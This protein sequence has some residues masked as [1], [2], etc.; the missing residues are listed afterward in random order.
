MSQYVKSVLYGKGGWLALTTVTAVVL[1]ATVSLVTQTTLFSRAAISGLTVDPLITTANR[2]I[3]A[4]SL[5]VPV[6]GIDVVGSAGESIDYV[7]VSVDDAGGGE[8]TYATDLAALASGVNE[9]SG[10]ALYVDDG[11]SSGQFDSTDSI[12]SSSALEDNG[13]GEV[14]VNVTASLPANDTGANSGDDFYIV[15][16]SGAD[17]ADTDAGDDFDVKVDNGDLVFSDASTNGAE[18]A[19]T[20]NLI[21]DPT[22]PTVSS[23]TTVDADDDGFIDA[24]DVV[25]TDA[26]SSGLNDDFSGL[27]IDVAG[28][29]G[30]SVGT[31][32]T[33]GDLTIR[34]TVTEQTSPNF[35]TDAI[36]TVQVTANTTLSDLTVGRVRETTSSSITTSNGNLHAT[37]AA[38][39]STDGAAPA[40]VGVATDDTDGNGTVDRVTLTFSEPIDTVDSGGAVDG[41]NALEG[42]ENSCAIANQ[43]LSA[44]D[45][46]ESMDITVSSCTAGDTAITTTINYEQDGASTIF[47]NAAS[48]IEMEDEETTTNERDNAP[49]AILSSTT[50]DTDGDGTVNRV[51][52]AFSET[53]DI[54]DG[55]AG[56]GFNGLEGLENSC[57]IANQDLASNSVSSI[58]I[59]VSGCTASDTSITTT[60]NYE[61]DGTNTILD[62]S[63]SANEMDDEE[64]SG[65][66]VDGAPPA[67]LSIT[68]DDTSGDG[69]V[70][71]LTVAY[72]EQVDIVDTNAGADG[73]PG[74][75]GVTDSCAISNQDETASNVTSS[76]LTVGS[77]TASDTS[78]LVELSYNSGDA[79]TSI[80]DNASVEM[81]D[82]ETVATG[83]DGAPPAIL[84]I[85][86]DDT[87]GDG[88][89]DQLTVAYSEQVDIVD[90]GTGT[91]GFGG[92][93]GL[94]DS[95]AI[96][97]QDETAS[98][99]TSSVLTVASCTASDTS[100]LVELA[101]NAGDATTS[102]IDNASVQM[103]DDETIAT[104]ID[105]A[106]PAIL[107][108]TSDDTNGN[109]NVD[110]IILVYSEQV[111]ITDGA[112]GDAFP[113]VTFS[114]SCVAANADYAANNATSSTITVSSCTSNDTS[115]TVDPTYAAASGQIQDNAATPVEMD[116][117]ETVT[118]IDNAPPAFISST[119]DDTDGNGNVDQ[120]T[121][122]Y[123]EAVDITD[124]SGADAFPGVTFS[125]SCVAA[126][127]DY[128]ANNATSSTI[129]VA[130]CTSNDTSITVDPTY[131]SAS[132]QIQDNA[133][134]PV[135][136][137]NGETVTG[138]D[139]AP[140][141][142]LSITTDDTSGDGTVDQLTV[143]YSEQVDIV[144]TNAAA[145]GFPGF[146]G[147]TDS[148]AI[149]NQDETASNVTSSVLTVASCTAS[150]TAILVELSYNSGDANTSII[151]NAT[152]E[153][154][155]NE[156]VSTGLDG[157]PPAILT[158]TT[159][160]TNSDGTVDQ[161]ELV[162][163]ESI[164]TVDNGGAGD[165]FDAFEGLQNSCTISNQDLSASDDTTT[166][167]LTLSNCTASSTSI[168][169]T[170]NYE[171]D[172]VSTIRD[173]AVTPVEMDDEEAAGSAVDG[174]PPVMLDADTLDG[175]T[176][177]TDGAM[178]G[179]AANG[180]LD[181]LEMLFSESISDASVTLGNFTLSNGGTVSSG[182]SGATA[183][184]TLYYLVIDNTTFATDGTPTITYTAGTLDDSAAPSNLT[185][186]EAEVA[187]DTAAPAFTGAASGDND[188]DGDVDRLV[189]TFS[190][191]IN[192][193]DGVAGDGFSDIGLTASEGTATI[194]NSAYVESGNQLTL[195]VS[196][197]TTTEGTDVTINPTY[198]VNG[199]TVH[200][201]VGEGDSIEVLTGETMTGTDAAKPVALSA[202]FTDNGNNGSVD[203]AA[204]TFSESVA[205][206]TYE[207]ADWTITAG[208]I[209]MTD[210]TAGA[211]STVTLTLTVSA[212]TNET[213]GTTPPTVAYNRAS[214]TAD[215]IV[216]GSGNVL[217]N[218]SSLTLSDAAGPVA[219]SGTYEDVTSVDGQIDRLDILLTT[220]AS[221]TCTAIEAADWSFNTAGTIT[222]ASDPSGSCTISTATLQLPWAAEPNLTGGEID[223]VI[224]YTDA[225][226]ANSIIDSAG[227]DI[228]LSS[229]TVTDGA[230]P[231]I[232]SMSTMDD[233]SDGKVDMLS[234]VWTETVDDSDFAAAQ[235]SISGGLV[236]SGSL[237]TPTSVSDT[238][239]DNTNYV[240][241]TEAASGDTDA[242]G[243]YTAGAA[244]IQDFAVGNTSGADSQ[245]VTD[246]ARPAF[247]SAV[248]GDNNSDGTVDRLVLTFSEPVDVTDGG[249]DS[250]VTLA[251]SSGVVTVTAGS[252][253]ATNTETLTLTVGVD[254]NDAT[255]AT[256]S[257]TYAVAGTGQ[258]D[259]T[260]AGNLEMANTETVTGTDGA[261]PQI[262]D[263]SYR[264]TD[265]DGQ[266]DRVRISFSEPLDVSSTFSNSNLA[267]NTAGDFT[268]LAF[269]ASSTDL[270]SS[271]GLTSIDVDATTEATAEDTNSA[272]FLVETTGSYSL[273][274][275]IASPNTE[276]S[277]TIL[278]ADMTDEAAPIISNVAYQDEDLDGQIDQ[279]VITWTETMDAGTSNFEPSDVV[280]TVGDFTGLS[281]GTDS[282]TDQI[283]SNTST[284]TLDVDDLTAAAESTAV[285]TNSTTFT[286]G[287]AASTFV[288]ADAAGNTY[289]ALHTVSTADVEDD[290]AP[291]IDTVTIRETNNNG[292]IDTIAIG[293]SENLDTDDGAAPVLA[294]L[295]TI[296]LPD[297]Q[298]VTSA[299]ISDPAGSS[300]TVTLTSV[301][302]QSTINT[303]AGSTAVNGITT[304]WTDGTNQ[305][306]N[307][308]DSESVVDDAGPNMITASTQTADTDLDGMIDQITVT[309]SEDLTGSGVGT[310]D[311]TVASPSYTVSAASETSAGVVTLT[312]TE[313]SSADTGSTPTVRVCASGAGCI[314]DADAL[315]V[316]TQDHTVT[317]VDNAD[318]IL[319][320]ASPANS[321]QLIPA[322]ANFTLT[323][324]EDLAASSTT[325][326]NITATGTG[327]PTITLTESSAGVITVS[328]T[329][330]N[331]SSGATVTV[332]VTTGVVDPAGNTYNTAATVATEPYTF[333]TLN[334]SSSGGGGGGG[335]AS[336]VTVVSN[337]VT[338]TS[339]NGGQTLTGGGTHTIT[340]SSTGSLN[341]INL[342]YSVDGGANYGL[343][344]AGTAND[345]SHTWSVPNT[346]TSQARVKIVGRDAGG[347]TLATDTSDSNFII[348]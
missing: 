309:F 301:V 244:L 161:L 12:V 289:A 304:Q 208:D 32:S 221:Y 107:S 108:S 192:V 58:A 63:A 109:G 42:L 139:G 116:N 112:A 7:D 138:I 237:A 348:A 230:G 140:P 136:A 227:N 45:D 169:S 279:A 127:A 84:S 33:S 132:G 328:Q 130:S 160:D 38:V 232:V 303:A 231:V 262:V 121:I 302:G 311:F 148:C 242:T 280:E 253:A 73:F 57:T 36:P 264:D 41:F 291:V 89:V 13:A 104:G 35:D 144:D 44:S 102:I 5:Q 34:V 43:D 222:L 11:S 1:A 72:S 78:I 6:V 323:F 179:A 336:T 93:D 189:L 276:T 196:G 48:P 3:V 250:F 333:T 22:A 294:D 224:S 119:S 347:A 123:S 251:S 66:E 113:G 70:D 199:A 252:Y 292:L 152:V 86:T 305:T 62:E 255:A 223:P 122:V 314:R 324:S 245:A 96:S 243:T 18:V 185:V 153:M 128:A 166:M 92:F 30:E 77:C 170:I 101:Y 238:A 188:G 27:T 137:D 37:G 241:I 52:L 272:T 210:D 182:D 332:T 267:V 295:G 19:D 207:D 284:V 186:S 239:D 195:L 339:P 190:E 29:S 164:D 174:A 68:T 8:F 202:Q 163:S 271:D 287:F 156:T 145:D 105:G 110:Q 290:A 154:D 184:D 120:I 337:S 312:L 320:S 97:N 298:T 82:N 74:F 228:I 117:G 296:T 178:T 335:G 171:Q 168:T 21:F 191:A 151:D 326:G 346:A 266:I 147:L 53:V 315:T 67:I 99:T 293:W 219:L 257:P 260:A 98:N 46:T 278:A 331:F 143:A 80:I 226:T 341:N 322:S 345:G 55:N 79:N 16:R 180:R 135:E 124:G 65:S 115:I 330:G 131:A 146:D 327:S 71:Q 103:D 259:E 258:I 4:S 338:V 183:N 150:N 217:E 94:T 299:T 282:T 50:D 214:G 236:L 235:D 88:T 15:I 263:A 54:A 283:T 141:A 76:V 270:I 91:D 61:Q 155:D 25:F 261:A 329:S 126:N 59:T 51:T 134:T 177:G 229:F 26:Q 204:I 285:D 175:Y 56:D 203:R 297:G 159:D 308:D 225:G 14:R 28:Y 87:S 165:G 248:T 118:G 176:A 40:I 31:G 181:A 133:V 275:N 218:I 198:T 20:T 125:D 205:A 200:Q 256:I 216:D 321:G 17:D 247:I 158:A 215:S 277:V 306:A 268:A 317:A 162:F 201:I 316:A 249:T 206:G 286:I 49:P 212:D 273:V 246:N 167:D 106:P 233:D 193:T 149:S 83:T 288:F 342:Y 319:M 318:P 157:A 265:A 173:N 23:R 111:D 81:D 75:D 211:I 274:D 9:A 172:G 334:P 24:V 10:V 114:D 240:G 90:T 95:C 340:W 209:G 325:S 220:E 234:T 269:G 310:A 344:A 307:P 194:G 39:A 313:A 100:I 64:A 142:I 300:N 281:F 69:T 187:D 47:D 60:I 85:T 129:T 254:F 213:G 2:G 343:I 197:L